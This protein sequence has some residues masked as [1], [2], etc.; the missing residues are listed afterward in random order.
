MAANNNELKL[1][2]LRSEIRK[3]VRTFAEKLIGKLG[4]NLKSIT[5]IG[6]SL[7]RVLRSDRAGK[8]QSAGSKILTR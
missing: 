6:S 5:I 2:P 8:N 4:E 7:T 3:P 1:A